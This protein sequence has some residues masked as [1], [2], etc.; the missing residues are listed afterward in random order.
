MAYHL[1][2]EAQT[3]GQTGEMLAYLRQSASAGYLPAQEMLGIAL[4]QGGRASRQDYCEAKLWFLRAGEQGSELG[5]TAAEF[6]QREQRRDV[7][8]R[9]VH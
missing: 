3:T 9:C 8:L 1:A 5:R 7:K 4:A 6:M 2:L